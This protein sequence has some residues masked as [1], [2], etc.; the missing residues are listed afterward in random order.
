MNV[1]AGGLYTPF[2]ARVE[3]EVVFFYTSTGSDTEYFVK[4][5][6]GSQSVSFVNKG[7]EDEGSDGE[8]SKGRDKLVFGELEMQDSTR[9]LISK[10]AYRRFLACE[11]SKGVADNLYQTGG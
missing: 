6:N 5:K 9:G 11:I 3:P 8:G 2:Y 1:R 7:P 4:Y 10:K